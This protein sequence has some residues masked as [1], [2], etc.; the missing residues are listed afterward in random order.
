MT[1]SPSGRAEAVGAARA[2]VEL[3][4]G[5]AAVRPLS[6]IATRRDARF[7][8][9]LAVRFGPVGRTRATGFRPLLVAALAVAVLRA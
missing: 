3:A 9:C 4:L 2:A 6:A 1:M 5:L 7:G 8:R